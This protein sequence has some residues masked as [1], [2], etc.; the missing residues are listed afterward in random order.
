MT[1]PRHPNIGHS[2]FQR[3]LDYAKSRGEDFNLLLLRYGVERILYRLSISPHA[4]R[5]ILKGASLFLVWR[6]HNY[7]TTKDTDLLASGPSDPASLAEILRQ[8]CGCAPPDVDGIEFLPA[9]VLATPIREEQAYD[10]VRVTLE[11]RLHHAHVPVQVDIGFGDRVTPEPE[12]VEFPTLLGG[13]APHLLAYPRETMVAEKLEAMVYLGA[14]N[15]RMKDFYDVWLLSRLYEFDGTTLCAAVGNTFHRR[16]TPLSRETPV[17]FTDAFC[18]DVQKR[19]QWRAFVRKAKPEQALDDLEAI[20]AAVA[21]F[22]LPVIETVRED[23][24]FELTWHPGGPWT[25]SSKIVAK[26]NGS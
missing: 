5:F 20:I 11:G 10:G 6:G 22:L 17:A 14:A 3:L 23:R 1:P 2:V 7:R 24:R 19:R 21:A 15:S 9:S 12:R 16:S 8:I 13:P 25:R 26:R 4:E 18:K